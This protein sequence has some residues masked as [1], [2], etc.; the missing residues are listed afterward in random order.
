M[1]FFTPFSFRIK[2]FLIFEPFLQRILPADA[3]VYADHPLGWSDRYH[4]RAVEVRQPAKI[5]LCCPC[6]A[7]H[8]VKAKIRCILLGVPQAMHPHPAGV[9]ILHQP[10]DI[11]VLAGPDMLDCEAADADVGILPAQPLELVQ[12][13]GPVPDGDAP[14]PCLSFQLGPHAPYSVIADDCIHIQLK[15]VLDAVLVDESNVPA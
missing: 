4:L 2:V 13:P 7:V 12:A 3:V 15:E 10:P 6:R 1:S 11:A 9:C 14:L 5:D 8:T